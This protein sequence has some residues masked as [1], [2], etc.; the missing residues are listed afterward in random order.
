MYLS[1]GEPLLPGK[2]GWGRAGSSLP[3]LHGY[4]TQV[5]GAKWSSPVVGR[6]E[7]RRDTCLSMSQFPLGDMGLISVELPRAVMMR[8]VGDRMEGARSQSWLV[9]GTPTMATERQLE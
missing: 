6:G 7:S 9:A 2:A 8:F 5:V 1:Q 3:S 4:D